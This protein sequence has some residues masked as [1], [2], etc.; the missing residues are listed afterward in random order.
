VNWKE[1]MAALANT[2]CMHW[3]MEHDKPS[4]DERFAK[5]SIAAAKKL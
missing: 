4:D 3:V 2:K 1:I 5:R